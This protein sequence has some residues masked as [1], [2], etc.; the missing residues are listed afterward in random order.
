MELKPD[1][2]RD[3]SEKQVSVKIN[4]YAIPM[5]WPNH[6]V[7]KVFELIEKQGKDKK[8]DNLEEEEKKLAAKCLE[9]EKEE[10]WKVPELDKV[11]DPFHNKFNL[12]DPTG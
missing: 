4:Q 9:I 1:H 11:F 8:E 2:F 7:K 3:L 6:Q 5:I 10:K 12:E